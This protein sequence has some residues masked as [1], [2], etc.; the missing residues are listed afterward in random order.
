MQVKHSLDIQTRIPKNMDLYATL[1][2]RKNSDNKINL[3]IEMLLFLGASTVT[4][5]NQI[6]NKGVCK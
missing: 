4:Q 3:V 2:L 6:L 5:K 1:I